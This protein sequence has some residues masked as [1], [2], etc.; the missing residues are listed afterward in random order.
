[1]KTT[2]LLLVDSD[3]TS[4]ALVSQAAAETGHQLIQAHTSHEAFCIIERGLED[5][6][7]I[8]IDLDPGVHG[9][10]VLEAIDICATTPPVIVLTGLEEVCMCGIA[11]A[12]GAAAW[13]A[14]PFSAEK[15]AEIIEKVIDPAWRLDTYTSDLWGHPHHCRHGAFP[16]PG[17]HPQKLPAPTA[18]ECANL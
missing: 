18:L 6:A 4:G 15:L 7:A 3:S 5:V 17:C 13:I 9:L 1:M 11:F 2:A 8:I 16:C 14:K 12:R 10:A